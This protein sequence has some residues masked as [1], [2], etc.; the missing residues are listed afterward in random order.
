MKRAIIILVSLLAMAALALTCK[1][2]VPG[3]AE[4]QEL[5]GIVLDGNGEIVFDRTLV[6]GPYQ[7]GVDT[8][9]DAAALVR[10]YA[11]NGFEGA[12]YTRTLPGDKGAV[13]VSPGNANIFY[14]VYFE[15]DG[16][17][18]FTLNIK[19]AVAMGDDEMGTGHAGTYH[20][21]TVCGFTWRSTSSVCPMASTHDK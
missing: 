11:G 20:K 17:P 3:E 16:I 5:K 19:D 18:S 7:I 6:N 1:K 8:E 10:L 13:R 15:V 12:E 4:V 21:C 9:A 2:D 14:S